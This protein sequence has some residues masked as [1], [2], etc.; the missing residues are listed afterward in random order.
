MRAL[1][2]GINFFGR[3]RHASTI[4]EIL[5]S[6]LFWHF[7]HVRSAR[8]LTWPYLS[9]RFVTWLISERKEP[10]DHLYAVVLV[11]SEKFN[12]CAVYVLPGHN[13]HGRR[14]FSVGIFCQGGVVVFVTQDSEC[15]LSHVILTFSV[16][17]VT[18]QQLLKYF[19][20]DCSGTLVTSSQQK[21]LPW[22]YLSVR[23]VTWLISERKEPLERLCAVILVTSDNVYLMCSLGF[24]WAQ[25][26]RAKA[27]FC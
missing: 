1:S 25:L 23:S 15:V 26:S 13:R 14:L 18:R 19:Y 12:W 2:C 17:S 8:T 10:L 3:F 21:L 24:T 6:R 9:V 4:A 22:P 20:H 5:L 11:T 7:G 16:A 27:F